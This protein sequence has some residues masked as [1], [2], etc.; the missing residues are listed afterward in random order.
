MGLAVLSAPSLRSPWPRKPSGSILLCL[1][2]DTASNGQ[3][4]L[5]TVSLCAGRAALHVA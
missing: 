4:F 5:S 3:S 2:E 1:P